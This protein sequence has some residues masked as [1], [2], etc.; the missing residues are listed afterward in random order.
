MCTIPVVYSISYIQKQ[1]I[2]ISELA[3][4]NMILE[5]IMNDQDE[6]ISLQDEKI[7]ILENKLRD[8]EVIINEKKN[9]EQ[10]TKQ[11][12]GVFNLSFYSKEQFPNSKTKTGVMPQSG[13]TVAVD[14]NVIP[15]GT[16]LYIEGFGIRIAQDTGGAI[17]GNKLD[18]FVNTTA[19]AL[20][21][22]KQN[23]K[24]WVIK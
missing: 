8:A 19:E 24:V 3:K 14:P 4:Q 6:I 16:K 7:Q 2:V 22:G 9:T 21:L 15:L 17:K 20:Q 13:V 11:Y 23:R 1:Q 10:D 5:E 18:V 12:L